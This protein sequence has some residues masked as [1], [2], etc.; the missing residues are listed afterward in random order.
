[1]NY[2]GLLTLLKTFSK[3]FE[4]TI[5]EHVSHHLKSKFNPHQHELIKSK[6]TSTNLVAHLDFV[7]C[8]VHSHPQ[9]EAIYFDISNA[10]D[11]VS[12][13]LLLRKHDGFRL[14]TTYVTWFRSYLPNR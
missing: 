13:P 6:S 2:Y 4:T 7:T 14:S 11:P 9:V 8:L 12:R 5:N 1:V 10:F 3:I